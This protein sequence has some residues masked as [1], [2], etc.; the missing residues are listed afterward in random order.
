MKN[1]KNNFA[2][3]GKSSLSKNGHLPELGEIKNGHDAVFNRIMNGKTLGFTC[4][5]SGTG[6]IDVFDVEGW[7][8]GGTL[9]GKESG[10]NLEIYGTYN[11]R[12]SG[13]NVLATIPGSGTGETVV[14]GSIYGEANIQAAFA[15]NETFELVPNNDLSKVAGDDPVSLQDFVTLKYANENFQALI[16]AYYGV[17]VSSGGV[18]SLTDGVPNSAVMAGE[19][20]IIID[21]Q[22]NSTNN[23]KVVRFTSDGDASVYDTFDHVDGRRIQVGNDINVPP[24]PAS[25]GEGVMYFVGNRLYSFDMDS[26]GSGTNNNWS[27]ESG[28]LDAYLMQPGENLSIFNV[29]SAD[30][31]SMLLMEVNLNPNYEYVLDIAKLRVIE[32]FD[33]GITLDMYVE[34]IGGGTQSIA[35]PVNLQS[36]G[37]YTGSEFQHL[38]PGKQAGITSYPEKLV[39]EI[40]GGTINV[41]ILDV[42]INITRVKD[43]TP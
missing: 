37:I 36:T 1:S 18:V 23:L 11:D 8:A 43:Y 34:D 21:D 41:G 19:Y 20:G 13:T 4:N 5:S 38:V 33:A 9:F 35:N 10:G 27:P 6:N 26:E 31:T 30:S 28:A 12:V 2:F 15:T 3:R 16:T 25:A 7:H 42:L 29:M 24:D 17:M 14:E 22:Q 39:L 32:A 40:S